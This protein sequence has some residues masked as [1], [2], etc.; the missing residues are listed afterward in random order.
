MT[1]LIAALPRGRSWRC[2]AGAS[3]VAFTIVRE[4]ASVTLFGPDRAVS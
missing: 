4:L 2:D 3:P 1:L